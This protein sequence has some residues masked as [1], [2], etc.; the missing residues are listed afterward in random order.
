MEGVEDGGELEGGSCWAELTQACLVNI[1][2]RLTM[3]DRWRCAMMVCKPWLNACKDSSLNSVFD[4][5]TRFG[6]AAELPRF[7][8]PEFERRVDSMLRSVVLWSDGSLTEI[9]ARHCSD[10][11]LSLVAG[12]CANKMLT[13]PIHYDSVD[14]IE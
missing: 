8:T 10:R 2:S 7:W 6:R 12:R 13:F 14:W 3:E 5:E 9:R 11:S 1:L 4:L